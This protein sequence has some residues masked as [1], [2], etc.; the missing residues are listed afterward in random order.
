MPNRFVQLWCHVVFATRGRTPWIT[1]AIEPDLHAYMGGV[2]TRRKGQLVAVGGMP[3]HVH[4]LIQ[5]SP[6]FPLSSLVQEIKGASSRWMSLRLEASVFAWQRGYGLF[7]V[8]AYQVPRVKRYIANQQQHHRFM[9]FDA[10]RAAFERS[11][12]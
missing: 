7:S 3:D 10:E 9:S 8:S 2:V 4:L 12:A 5:A 1:A 11:L 6:A